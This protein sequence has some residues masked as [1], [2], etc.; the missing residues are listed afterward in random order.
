MLNYKPPHIYPDYTLTH[1]S[2]PHPFQGQHPVMKP[3]FL[4]QR[5]QVQ[6]ISPTSGFP[7]TLCV[8][9]CVCVLVPQS[10]PTL[11]D[12]MDCSP[13]GS[14]AHGILQARMWSGL[15]FPPS[16]GDLPDPGIELGSPAL[17]ADSLPPDPQ[18]KPPRST[19]VGGKDQL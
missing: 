13:L 6:L 18:G 17:Q 15:S 10:C 3:C 16:P 9:V 8:C 1:L 12:P 14:S 2:S 7:I 4:I 5:K 11:C 19:L